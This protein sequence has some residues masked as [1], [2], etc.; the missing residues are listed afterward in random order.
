MVRA[1]A[2]F[3][4]AR[5]GL[6]NVCSPHRGCGENFDPKDPK[7]NANVRSS[8]TNAITRVQVCALHTKV[9]ACLVH[10]DAVS[11]MQ[12]LLVQGVQVHLA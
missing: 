5:C 8:L 2:A 12:R 11:R 6:I 9:L 10:T 4:T 1:F 3:G 7:N